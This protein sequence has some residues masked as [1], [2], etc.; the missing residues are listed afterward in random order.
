MADI[1]FALT[2]LGAT[3]TAGG[4]QEGFP[5]DNAIDGSDVSYWR[6]AGG[7]WWWAVDLGSAQYITAVRFLQSAN[8]TG[9]YSTNTKVE[10][11]NDGAT[12]I[13][14]VNATTTYAWN[15][16]LTG[17]LTAR[18]WRLTCN[19][20]ASQGWILYTVECN[21]PTDAPPPPSNP[22]CTNLQAWLDGLEA[23]W[24]PCVETWLEEN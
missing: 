10:Y 5:P 14:L 3:A 1:N 19:S 23:Y 12:W 9:N 15:E 4:S 13:T 17:G 7:N 21:G 16:V 2:A 6:V 11:S 24:V 20:G 22:N 8:G 18:Y